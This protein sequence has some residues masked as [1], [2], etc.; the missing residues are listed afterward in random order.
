VK[1]LLIFFTLVIGS[2]VYVHHSLQD[3]AALRYIDEH[4]RARGVPEATYY[5]GQGY[6]IFQDLQTAATY[7]SRAAERY[8]SLALGDDAHFSYLQCLDDT[9]SLSRSDLIEA[10]KAYLEKY[11]NGRHSELVKNRLDAYATGGR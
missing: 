3:G 1:T 8:P 2:M 10:Y 5:I 7:F 4:P 6:Y 11:P 9:V